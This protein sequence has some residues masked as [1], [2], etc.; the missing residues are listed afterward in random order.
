[1]PDETPAPKSHP[2]TEEERQDGRARQAK[3]KKKK[4]RR[5]ATHDDSKNQNGLLDVSGGGYRSKESYVEAMLTD[6]RGDIADHLRS[7]HNFPVQSAET[8]RLSTKNGLKKKRK[9]WGSACLL[10][11]AGNLLVRNSSYAYRYSI[12]LAVHE[13]YPSRSCS[14]EVVKEVEE[15][16]TR[17]MNEDGGVLLDGGAAG[18]RRIATP[19][20]W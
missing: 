16:R 13:L 8:T 19:S 20:C 2:R 6:H 10:V 14:V 11:L 12:L 9:R 7:I 1:L 15:L 17:G 3:K 4:A 5:R 18:G